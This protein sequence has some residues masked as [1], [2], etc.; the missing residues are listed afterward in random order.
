VT[1]ARRALSACSDQAGK[2]LSFTAYVI[3]SLGRAVHANPHLHAYLNWRRR[4]V[5][6]QH[7][8]I[9]TMIEVDWEGSPVPMPHVLKR[10]DERDYLA[11]SDE[12]RSVQTDPSTSPGWRYLKWFV[13]LPGFLRKSFA[14]IV[15]RVPRSFRAYSSPVLV[16]AVGMFGKG[17]GW[18]I[19]KPSQT[20]TVTLGGIAER[21]GVVEGEIEIREYLDITISID[22]DIVDGAPA[23]R[24]IEKFRRT[25][26]QAAALRDLGHTS[27]DG[28]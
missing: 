4:L 8:N 13:S 11:I 2:K 20:L 19:P 6:F 25:L 27:V 24:F 1:E 14:W 12:L 26:E 9:G 18:G 7:V 17:G 21:P 28:L 16:T 23:A 22:H 5:I 10:V 3:H 15:M